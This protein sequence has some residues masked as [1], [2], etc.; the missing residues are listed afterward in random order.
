MSRLG[1][2]SAWRGG[3]V[4]EVARLRDADSRS[5]HSLAWACASR[6]LCP[7]LARAQPRRDFSWA[8]WAVLGRGEKSRRCVRPLSCYYSCSSDAA[9]RL[10]LAKANPPPARPRAR[11]RRRHSRFGIRLAVPHSGT[12]FRDNRK[13]WS[14]A[15][16]SGVERGSHAA[17]TRTSGPRCVACRRVACLA[18]LPACFRA[19]WPAL[20]ASLLF[21]LP[22]RFRFL[23]FLPARARRASA[24]LRFHRPPPLPRRR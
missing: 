15:P 18:A 19:R 22:R 21:L 9:G 4:G 17:R 11:P 20:A 8:P 6:R 1:W 16:R 23:L 12:R 24:V 3:G 14:S 7:A 2:P 13:E 5:P 10:V